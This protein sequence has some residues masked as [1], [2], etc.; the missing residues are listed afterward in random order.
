MIL[1]IYVYQHCFPMTALKEIPQEVHRY[2]VEEKEAA[3]P[4][5]CLICGS[6]PFFIGYIEKSSPNQMLIYSLCSECYAKQESA[7]VV[8]KIIGYYETT[9]KNTPILLVRR[10]AC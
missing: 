7:G 9:R 2:I 1:P 6:P 10:E 3:L 4:Y 8:E 5:G